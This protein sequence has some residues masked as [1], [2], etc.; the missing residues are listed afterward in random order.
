MEAEARQELSDNQAGSRFELRVGG[1]VAGFIEYHRRGSQQ[2]NLIHTEV[3]DR[4]Q[5][6]GLAGK[7]ARFALDTAR[8]Q[9]L[10]VLPS[11]PY[12]RRWIGKH[13]GYLDLVPRDRRDEFGLPAETPR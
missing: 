6:A 2:I 5:G 13:P 7:L 12:I 11:C 8:E 10:D 1:E 3:D 4:F 9:Q